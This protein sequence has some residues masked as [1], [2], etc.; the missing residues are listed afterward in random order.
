[1]DKQSSWEFKGRKLYSLALRT[2]KKLN[3]GVVFEPAL[4]E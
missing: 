4:V 3:K 2:G 1:M